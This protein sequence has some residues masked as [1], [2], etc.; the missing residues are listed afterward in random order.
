VASN[1]RLRALDISMSRGPT[2]AS[3]GLVLDSCP[4]LAR[5]SVWSCTQLSKALYSGHAR[6]V[7]GLSASLP[8]TGSADAAGLA[9]IDQAVS[10]WAALKVFGREGDVMPAAELG[11]A[12]AAASIL[13]W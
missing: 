10:S 12:A 8:V 13:E 3:I 4:S 6:A 1:R 2:D 5:L 7:R 11:D 9:V